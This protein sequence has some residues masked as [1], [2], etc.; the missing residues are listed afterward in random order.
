MSTT[1]IGTTQSKYQGGGYRD[2]MS[3][4]TNKTGKLKGIVSPRGEEQSK[5][6]KANKYSSKN[7]RSPPPEPHESAEYT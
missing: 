1:S 6:S 7:P 5:Q 2:G 4:K 3:E